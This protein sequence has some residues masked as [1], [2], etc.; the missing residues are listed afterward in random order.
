[1]PEITPKSYPKNIRILS[2]LFDSLSSLP[3]VI[4]GKIFHYNKRFYITGANRRIISR[5]S[6]SIIMPT[7][8]ANTTD[9]TI[10]W[11]GSV[12]ENT[13]GINKVYRINAFGKFS[14]ANAS[15]ILTIKIKIN[16]TT[17]T[18]LSSAL[19]VVTDEPGFLWMTGTIREIGVSGGISSHG[20]I[21]LGNTDIHEH[22]SNIVLNTTIANSIKITFQW[23]SANANNSATIDQAFLEALD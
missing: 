21:R 13:L 12:S 7:T 18:T 2:V 20:Y 22:D 15:S 23:S 3:S 4:A 14:T 1:M 10:V 11:T 9:E 5:A 17:V 19:G 8:I 6:D 16:G